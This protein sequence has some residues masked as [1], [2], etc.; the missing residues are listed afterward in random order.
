M[1]QLIEN[2]LTFVIGLLED[3]GYLSRLSVLM[4][5]SLRS[6]GL[7]GKGVLPLVL[8]FSCITM[9]ILTTRMLPTKK[10][11]I[12]TTFLLLLGYPCAPL[13]ALITEIEVSNIKLAAAT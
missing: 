13:L 12:I 2:M 7:T 9:A 8:G 5:R 3:S 11:R 1:N 4:D 6:L 10:E